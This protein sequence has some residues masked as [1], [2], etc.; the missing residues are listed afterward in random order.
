MNKTITRIQLYKSDDILGNKV[1]GYLDVRNEFPL[2]LTM[3]IGDIRD[4]SKRT[5]SFSKTIKLSGSKNNNL[6]LNNYFDI[7][8]KSLN[9][10]I[11]KKQRCAIIQNGIVILDNLYLRLIN[12]FK[13]QS[14]SLLIDELVEY[15]VE[16]RDNVGDFF[17]EINTK[18]LTDLNIS[19]FNHIYENT[20]IINSFTHSYK[21]GYSYTL[22]WNP[23]SV[24][25]ISELLPGLFAKTYFDKIHSDAGYTYE[26]LG[27]TDSNFKFDKLFIPYSG[28]KKKL[29]KEFIEDERVSANKLA[30]TQTLQITQ[31]TYTTSSG[32]SQLNIDE[33]VID[34]QGYYNSNLYEVPY[35]IL[36]PNKLDWKVNIEW[37][38]FVHNGNAENIETRYLVD[39]LYEELEN[40]VRPRIQVRK[41]NSP[42][43]QVGYM[44]LNPQTLAQ[45]G[46]EVAGMN[47]LVGNP[48]VYVDANGFINFYPNFRV[49]ANSERFIA[50]GVEEFV[51]NP[52]NFDINDLLTTRS[53]LSTKLDNYQF[54]WQVQ[55]GF[56]DFRLASY[57]LKVKS[58]SIEIAPNSDSAL[59]PGTMLDMNRFIPKKVK[60]GQFLKSIYQKY[61]LFVEVDKSDP[62]KLIYKTRDRYYDEGEFKDWTY[63]LSKDRSQIINFVPEISAK[64][65]IL[66]YKDDNNDF[67]LKSYKDEV[68]ETY[69]QIEVIFDNEN[70]RGIERKEE[71]FSPTININTDFGAN[72]PVLNAD[73]KFNI[74]T[75]L[76]NGVKS[77]G[78]YSIIES[79]ST[80]TTINYYPFISMLDEIENP[81]Y[82]IS[83]APCDYYA[84]DIKNY[85]SNN[86]Y[87]NFWR[88]TFAQI[89]Q[90]KIL[91]AYF[92]LN[93]EDIFK[94]KLSDKI[95]VNNAIWYINQIID[96]NANGVQLT[97]VELLSVEDD[98][99][100]PRF[101]RIIKPS[102]PS[103]DGKFPF[104]PILD[105]VRPVG[106]IGPIRDAVKE[107]IRIRNNNTS[108]ESGK[109]N[110]SINLGSRNVINGTAV[111]IGSDKSIEEDG[112]Y[113]H[114]TSLTDGRLKINDDTKLDG[115]GLT[116]GDINI[117][118]SATFSGITLN[119]SYI[120][121]EYW[122]DD[123]VVDG[124]ITSIGFGLD[125]DT[126][127]TSIDINADIINIGSSGSTINIL[128]N[129][130]SYTNE[131]FDAY[132][133]ANSANFTAAITVPINTIRTSSSAFSLTASEI[134]FNKKMKIYIDY[135]VSNEVAAGSARSTSFGWLDLDTGS[136]FGEVDGTRVFMYNRLTGPGQ[137]TGAG[138]AILEVN[139]GDVLRLR[140]QRL[141]GSD[142]LRCR[143]LGCGIV[144]QE[145]KDKAIIQGEIFNPQLS[146]IDRVSS[147][148]VNV[149][150]YDLDVFLLGGGATAT[151]VNLP[152]VLID[153]VKYTFKDWTGS[154]NTYNITINAFG[155]DTIDGTSS[156]T[157]NIDYQSIT[158]VS[159][160]GYGWYII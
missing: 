62:N 28:D 105:P 138:S 107:V 111:I 86:L 67:L 135:R 58:I 12:V 153:G 96:Y 42:T 134:T 143:A 83:Y 36:P 8:T 27:L 99:R 126:G 55:G 22:P 18:E 14:N 48:A 117:N 130:P 88:R 136:G 155:G 68:G 129:I 128:G 84:Y 116:I 110:D 125:G 29:N 124:T 49:G 118:S 64:R 154:S 54:G 145:I 81:S 151:S 69:G 147:S 119:S 156:Y 23:T 50:S 73:F 47:N 78:D 1:Q 106:P 26:W 157:M 74:R 120:I 115:E 94:L 41:M 146:R 102:I 92:I 121:D 3:G 137:A 132:N 5:G 10:D 30:T 123:Y 141:A 44:N 35:S 24:Y 140:T 15:E 104:E 77:C 133:S 148:V 34:N 37:E 82:D 2:P 149:E 38:L 40:G 39:N 71:I 43:A 101:G 70:V 32:A 80:S 75:L 72:L 122:D 89:N 150:N 20:N 103:L 90:G 16:V 100:L 9:F 93:E 108:V 4:I 109:Y 57:R 159:Y 158:I 142:T 52:T 98:I 45:F 6:L 85:T 21:E 11:N 95:K 87:T 33:N 61:N 60:Q 139:P 131:D 76:H 59:L 144:I 17:N 25:S 127:D 79:L 46:S 97:K 65:N 63:K 160:S 113:I 56:Y 114:D 31:P 112:Y 91:T 19:E 51:I 152:E 7:N 66:T 13:T 53:V